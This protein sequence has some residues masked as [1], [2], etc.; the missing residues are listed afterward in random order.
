MRLKMDNRFM[1]E[2]RE[3]Q[4]LLVHD[5]DDTPVSIEETVGKERSEEQSDLGGSVIELSMNSVVGLTSLQTTKLE[6][7][8]RNKEVVV[9]NDSGASHNFISNNLV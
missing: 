7:Q 2:S 1:C 5:E 3:L 6:G 9:L 8:V 4:V